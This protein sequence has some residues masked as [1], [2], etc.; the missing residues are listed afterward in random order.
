M[1]TG[2]LPYGVEVSKIRTRKQQQKLQYRSALDDNRE[3]PA[4]IDA[5]FRKAVHPDPR[6]RYE[7]LSEFMFDLRHPNKS[8]TDSRPAPLLERN[9][10]L[11]WQALSALLFIAV[12]VLF[13]VLFRVK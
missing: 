12:M 8:L 1:L 10:L 5:A 2:R 7:E 3:I 11:F 9:P 13:G 4:W 6:R